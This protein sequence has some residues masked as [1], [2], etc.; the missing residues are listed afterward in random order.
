MRKLKHMISKKRGFTLIEVTV[1]SVITVTFIAAMVSFFIQSLKSYQAGYNQTAATNEGRVGIGK[2]G[3]FLREASD[4]DI[5]EYGLVLVIEGD[6][7]DTPFDRS[8]DVR[9]LLFCEY[10]GRYN[11]KGY[12]LYDMKFVEMYDSGGE[13]YYGYY[14][15]DDALTIVKDISPY[16]EEYEIFKMEGN[17]V[18]IKYMIDKGSGDSNESLQSSDFNLTVNMRNKV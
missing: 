4:A 9:S 8:D 15:G 2:I 5:Y 16:H 13:G 6:I 3:K 14:E 18:S 10:N 1:V 12:P 17:T 7:Y 11:K